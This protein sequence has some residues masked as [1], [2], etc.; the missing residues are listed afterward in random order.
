MLVAD[1]GQDPTRHRQRAQ[2]YFAAGLVTEDRTAVD[3]CYL[4]RVLLS[5]DSVNESCEAMPWRTGNNSHVAFMIETKSTLAVY[6][7]NGCGYD[8]VNAQASMGV[9]A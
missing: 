7:V 8:Y 3:V 9:H 4:F 1:G 2:S 6:W 5:S